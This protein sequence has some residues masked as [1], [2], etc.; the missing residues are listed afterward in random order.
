MD[1]SDVEVV[2]DWAALAAGDLSVALSDEAFRRAARAQL[3]PHTAPGFVTEAEGRV[4]ERFGGRREGVDELIEG[5]RL[6]ADGYRHLHVEVL[7]A[8]KLQEGRIFLPLVMRTE[9]GDGA[10]ASVEAG[11]LFTVVDGAVTRLQMFG[12]RARALEAA[13]L[14]AP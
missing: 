11:A 13:G 3:A 5:W 6:V 10:E 4:F 9:D 1:L 8:D 14:S 7:S 12:E 2:R